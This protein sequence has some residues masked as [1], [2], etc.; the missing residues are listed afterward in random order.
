MGRDKSHGSSCGGGQSS[1]E[2]LLGASS[3]MKAPEQEADDI[4]I[5]APVQQ[6]VGTVGFLVSLYS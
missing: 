1:L 6:N 4:P 3:P 5:E 2:Y